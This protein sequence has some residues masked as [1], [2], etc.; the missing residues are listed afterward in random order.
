MPESFGAVPES[1]LVND[2]RLTVPATEHEQA[3]IDQVGSEF[4]E[5]MRA[6]G[7]ELGVDL[8]AFIAPRHRRVV[9]EAE[10][11]ERTI[12]GLGLD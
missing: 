9:T 1:V 12:G 7:F 11:D 10:L 8:W 5:A 6:R 2:L 4:G 3:V